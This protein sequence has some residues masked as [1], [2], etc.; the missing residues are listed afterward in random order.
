MPS[1]LLVAGTGACC[2]AAATAAC[3]RRCF[4]V[5]TICACSV[6]RDDRTQ[7]KTAILHRLAI[8]IATEFAV[9]I[10]WRQLGPSPW[11]PRGP[12]NQ[13][14]ASTV[15]DPVQRFM[16]YEAAYLAG[17]LDPAF[18]V[19]TANEYRHVADAPYHEDE[20]TWMRETTASIRPENIARNYSTRCARDSSREQCSI[21]PPVQVL[22]RSAIVHHA[23]SW[24][25]FT[26]TSRMGTFRAAPT[27][28]CA[29]TAKLSGW[30]RVA[31]AAR[32]RTS[33]VCRA[34]RSASLPTA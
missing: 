8:G 19:L 32:A 24:R 29:T 22:K 3:C 18:E 28:P 25:M 21:L 17:D 1:P 20:L 14:N 7:S 2:C 16:H 30:L 10:T 27:P 13:T 15:I 6:R 12:A 31:S 4:F 5:F 11:G 26:P 33:V 23:G 34:R 9:S